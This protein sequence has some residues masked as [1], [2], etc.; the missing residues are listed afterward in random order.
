ML[1]MRDD[2]ATWQDFAVCQ[3]MDPGMFYAAELSGSDTD[4]DPARAVCASCPVQT[5]CLEH[6]LARPE[7]FGMWGGVSAEGRR[8]IRRNRQRNAR[9]G[10][11]SLFD[12]DPT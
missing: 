9:A 12:Q 6:A 8:K 3:G 7:K 1:P 11:R 10:I 4:Y 2:E 5:D